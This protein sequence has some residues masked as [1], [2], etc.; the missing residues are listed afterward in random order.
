MCHVTAFKINCSLAPRS[1]QQACSS[2]G[3]YVGSSGRNRTID[4]YKKMRQSRG[5]IST[6]C[7]KQ[8]GK[9]LLALEI[10]N[11]TISLCSILISEQIY[12]S[13]TAWRI[14]SCLVWAERELYS[15]SRESWYKDNSRM[16]EGSE[17]ITCLN[18]AVRGSFC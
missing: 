16:R 14:A 8:R 4:N 18:G 1:D 6:W 12:W 17:S 3:P 7:K 10:S 2:P 9:S 15:P 11:L 13:N 5:C